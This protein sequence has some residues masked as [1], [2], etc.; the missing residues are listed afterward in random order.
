MTSLRLSP[1]PI[2]AHGGANRDLCNAIRPSWHN[3]R[4]RVRTEKTTAMAASAK[5]KFVT[6]LY[7][8]IL[9]LDLA[10]LDFGLYRILKYRRD[11]I[12]AFFDRRLPVLMA[13][14]VGTTRQDRLAEVQRRLAAQREKL[15]KSAQALGLI[16]AFAE[17]GAVLPALA[18]TPVAEEYRQ[19]SEEH[20]RFA[21]DAGFTQSEEERLYNHLYLFFSRYYPAFPERGH[22]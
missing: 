13:E 20:R 21:V 4:T 6:L 14:A 8:E 18:A 3:L 12:R 10:E 11:E 7:D 5:E 22:A 15:D 19:L 16:G 2:A 17:D 9:K 1:T